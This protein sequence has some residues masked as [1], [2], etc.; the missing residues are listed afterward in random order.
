MPDPTAL[1]FAFG[2]RTVEKTVEVAVVL[3]GEDMRTASAL[4]LRTGISRTDRGSGPERLCTPMRKS[5]RGLVPV[6][7][8]PLLICE[9][10]E[11]E[12]ANGQ[13]GHVGHRS[14]TFQPQEHEGQEGGRGL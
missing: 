10:E 14:D 9:P 4:V 1:P 3:R 13:E 11:V 6:R 5:L 12:H 7:I 8:P 2:F